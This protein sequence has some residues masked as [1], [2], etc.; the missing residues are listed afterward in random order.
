VQI[1]KDNGIT[2]GRRTPQPE[3]GL[4]PAGTTDVPWRS[5]LRTQAGAELPLCHPERSEGSFDLR[6]GK[7]L[8]LC[9]RMTKELLFITM[10]SRLLR[11]GHS[12]LE[13]CPR[14]LNRQGRRACCEVWHVGLL[15][16]HDMIFEGKDSSLGSV[17]NV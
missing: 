12:P 9:L 3:A 11:W 14:T 2:M 15:F 8:R 6:I 16:F 17:L 10:T 4:C 13:V 7:I 1:Q 5:L